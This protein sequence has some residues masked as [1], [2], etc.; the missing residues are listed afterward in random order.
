MVFISNEDTQYKI[1]LS[2][3]SISYLSFAAGTMRA[4]LLLFQEYEKGL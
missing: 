2:L 4:R 1:K 3:L